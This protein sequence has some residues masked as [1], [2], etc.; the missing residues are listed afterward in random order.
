MGRHRAG[1]SNPRLH[2]LYLDEQG[3]SRLSIYCRAAQ[4]E[5]EWSWIVQPNRHHLTRSESSERID[6]AGQANSVV[7]CSAVQKCRA[8]VQ[9]GSA[10]AMSSRTWRRRS[11]SPL[12]WG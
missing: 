3:S 2:G 5:E 12:R 9:H 6:S 1:D 10:V 8:E 7:K 11:M 4:M